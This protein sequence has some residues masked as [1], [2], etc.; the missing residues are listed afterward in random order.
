MENR[1]CKTSAEATIYKA[2][3]EKMD[4]ESIANVVHIIKEFIQSTDNNKKS[5][6]ELYKKLKS[7]PYSIRLGIIPILI[8]LAINEYSDNIILYY[9][10]REI[11]LNA[12][13]LIKINDI[14]QNYYLLT[15]KGTVDKL[16]YI[17]GLEEIYGIDNDSSNIRV[18]VSMLVD[19]MK[20][21][22][23]G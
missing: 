2:T 16:N 15:E 7:K 5:F 3:V 22:I 18:N 4:N 6:E 12:L 23:F 14:P 21:W 11:E 8:A 1:K 10:N 9:M 19:S 17:S 13:N 20:K